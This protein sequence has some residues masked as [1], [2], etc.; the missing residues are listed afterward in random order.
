M[1]I[2]SENYKDWELTLFGWTGN[3]KKT[4]RSRLLRM[5]EE[6]RRRQAE[7]IGKTSAKQNRPAESGRFFD[8]VANFL[9]KD[10]GI[11]LGT[12]NVLIYVKGRGI[13][14]DEPAYVARDTETSEV[15]AVGESAKN[16][17]GRTPKGVEVV[18]PLR[19]GVIADY[20]TT[21][22]MLRY[23][24]SKAL[25]SRPLFKPRII[26]CVPSGTTSVERR[27]VLEATLQAGA[28]KTVLVE[29][30]LAAAL[31]VGLD[32]VKSAGG[33]L[34]D[35]GGGT[36]DIAVLSRTGVVVSESLRIGSDVFDE[37]VISY[38]KRKRKL[39]IG[40]SSAERLKISVGTTDRKA[41]VV[42][43][44]VRGRDL[45]TGLPKVS[46][47]TSKE[48][49]KALEAPMNEIIESI[50]SVLEKT[51]PELLA[52]ISDRGI[53]LTGGGALI[54]GFDRTLSH[55]L[56]MPAF[57]ADSPMYS[58]IVGT[59]RALKEMGHFRDTLDELQG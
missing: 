4:D 10:V 28:R 18:R 3:R 59:G 50:K 52:D 24:V 14:L 53:V 34:V 48:I 33:M 56:G 36:T 23:F 5:R 58:V 55:G 49:Q 41:P 27:A 12:A 31:G 38:L 9:S 2:S 40:E 51:P 42:E 15:L 13:V 54:D 37:A 32:G 7:P 26:V 6:R 11:D 29:E 1:I 43:A 35:V 25:P 22:Y 45:V 57:L 19:H 16:M 17:R 20:D 8:T 47:V 46:V 44:Q 30:P 21:E 39:L